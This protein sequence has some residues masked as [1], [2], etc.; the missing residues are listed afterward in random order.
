M[1]RL[2]SH[3]KKTKALVEMCDSVALNHIRE[4]EDFYSEL[5]SEEKSDV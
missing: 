2:N 4:R 3:V 1:E 5:I